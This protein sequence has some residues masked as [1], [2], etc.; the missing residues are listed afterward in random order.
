MDK[1]RKTIFHDD[2]DEHEDKTSVEEEDENE[3]DSD[4]DTDDDTAWDELVLQSFEKYKDTFDD[5][6]ASYENSGMPSDEAKR[7]AFEDMHHIYKGDVAL[8]YEQMLN[9]MH[10]LEKSRY[11]EKIMEDVEQFQENHPYEKALRLAIRK[12]KDLFYEII[13]NVDIMSSDDDEEE[14]EV[15]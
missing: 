7:L 15:V 2:D 11:H 9:N 5:A 1:P 10:H 6:R 3:D 4:T 13:D 8:Q 12:N 14:M